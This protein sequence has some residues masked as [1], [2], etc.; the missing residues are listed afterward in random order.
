MPSTSNSTSTTKPA[1]TLIRRDATASDSTLAQLE[2]VKAQLV[3]IEAALRAER[4]RAARAARVGAP[5]ILTC[6]KQCGHLTAAQLLARPELAGIAK[7]SLWLHL[8]ALERE[9]KV[10]FRVTHAGQGGR[11]VTEIYHADAIVT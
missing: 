1:L 10:W 6:L 3:Q 11:K 5:E 2:A 4:E 9:G 7:S 8:N